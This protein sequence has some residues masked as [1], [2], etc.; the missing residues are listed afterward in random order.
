MHRAFCTETDWSYIENFICTKS[1]CG[2]RISIIEYSLKALLTGENI[3]YMLVDPSN[4][5]VYVGYGHDRK[6][7]FG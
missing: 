3:S 2:S 1:L 7:L 4:I 5:H 6:S